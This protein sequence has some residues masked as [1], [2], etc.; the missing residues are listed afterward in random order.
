MWLLCTLVSVVALGL[1]ALHDPKRLRFRQKL[2][3]VGAIGRVEAQ[4]WPVGARRLLAILMVL[5]GVLLGIMGLW[6][7][8]MLWLGLTVTAGWL[9][10]EIIS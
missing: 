5:P 8:F 6:A 9:L 4:P 3:R 2:F 7:G 10:V 1:A